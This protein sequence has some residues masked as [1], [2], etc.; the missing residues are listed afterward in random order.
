MLEIQPIILQII[1]DK[2]PFLATSWAGTMGERNPY[3]SNDLRVRNR[4]RKNIHSSVDFQVMGKALATTTR[5]L[6]CLVEQ[7]A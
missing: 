6:S 2:V 7:K 4:G 5:A 3:F 1:A